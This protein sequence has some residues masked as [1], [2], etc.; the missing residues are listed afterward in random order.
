MSKKKNR[1][2]TIVSE[3]NEITTNDVEEEVIEE[4]PSE[5]DS[6]TDTVTT[7]DEDETVVEEELTNEVPVEDSINIAEPEVVTDDESNVDADTSDTDS[8]VEEELPEMEDL[9]DIINNLPDNFGDKIDE[10]PDADVTNGN[11]DPDAGAV[12][13]LPEI[14][15]KYYCEMVTGTNDSHVVEQ[16]L[17]KFDFPFI[18]TAVGAVLVG[19]YKTEQ[20]AKVG[21][22]SL[23]AKGLRASVITFVDCK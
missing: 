1:I 5:D 2:P 4:S 22:K 15:G 23:L 10:T 16:R 6:N 17:E 18:V 8:V 3:G 9:D 14:D 20:D 19:P 13:P 11:A 21:V 12:D 7:V